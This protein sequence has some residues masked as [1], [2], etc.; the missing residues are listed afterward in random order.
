MQKKEI[1]D[2][3][4]EN[5]NSFDFSLE[6]LELLESMDVNTMGLMDEENYQVTN[7][8]S[9]IAT[10]D[11]AFNIFNEDIIDILE[12]SE[13]NS[14]EKEIIL[15][16]F[17]YC[18]EM[19]NYLV[20]NNCQ[21]PSV[22]SAISI[23]DCLLVFDKTI[24]II[25]HL[26]EDTDDILDDETLSMLEAD[27]KI[28]STYN[29][30]IELISGYISENPIIKD[31]MTHIARAAVA[32]T[33]SVLENGYCAT[34]IEYEQITKVDYSMAEITIKFSDFIIK[35]EKLLEN[36]KLD[37][38]VVEYLEKIKEGYELYKGYQYH[39]LAYSYREGKML[40]KCNKM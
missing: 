16:N 32:Y 40:E 26:R 37:Q 39:S 6:E 34:G 35:I 11:L 18:Y 28:C 9:K 12:E 14:Y 22:L 38:K 33:S 25:N 7:V 20:N 27:D 29:N 19:M 21:H 15:N 8:L 17:S 4:R 36:N 5:I 13:L 31:I 3:F 1:F 2:Y 24:T 30:C 23:A 10:Y